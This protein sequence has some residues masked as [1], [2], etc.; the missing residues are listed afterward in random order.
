MAGARLGVIDSFVTAALSRPV[1]VPAAEAVPKCPF[2]AVEGTE[3]FAACDSMLTVPPVV[4]IDVCGLLSAVAWPPA[5]RDALLPRPTSLPWAASSDSRPLGAAIENGGVDCVVMLVEAGSTTQHD[6]IHGICPWHLA[7]SSE[8]CNVR[9]VQLLWDACGGVPD[10]T[11]CTIQCPGRLH[12]AAIVGDVPAMHAALDLADCAL[13]WQDGASALAV[14]IMHRRVDFVAGWLARRPDDVHPPCCGVEEAA[15]MTGL[16]APKHDPFLPPRPS[17]VQLTPLQLAVYCGQ[18]AMV[19]LLLDAGATYGDDVAAHVWAAL[20]DRERLFAALNGDGGDVWRR[21]LLPGCHVTV[22]MI[23]AVGGQTDIVRDIMRPASDALSR[24]ARPYVSAWE[25]ALPSAASSGDPA[26]MALLLPCVTSTDRD[27]LE[28]TM[29]QAAKRGDVPVADTVL[30]WCKFKTDTVRDRALR[31]ALTAALQAH[32][33]L[34]ALWAREAGAV[35]DAAVMERDGRLVHT[36]RRGDRTRLAAWATTSGAGEL[37]EVARALLVASEMGDVASVEV[38]LAALRDGA[39]TGTR[40]LVSEACGGA[41]CAAAARGHMSTLQALLSAGVP[42]D[43]AAASGRTA[44]MAAC[45]ALQLQAVTALLSAGASVDAVDAAG[46]TLLHHLASSRPGALPYSIAAAVARHLARLL[47]RHGAHVHA[48]TVHGQT[49]L[50]VAVSNQAWE[51][52]PLVD[53]LLE[54]GADPHCVDDEDC[55]A[56]TAAFLRGR[57]RTVRAI[58]HRSKVSLN[59]VLRNGELPLSQW[60]SHSRTARGYSLTTTPPMSHYD[61]L[62]LVAPRMH[63][64]AVN[65]RGETPLHWALA[66]L[67]WPAISILL[68]AGAPAARG[69][70]ASPSCFALAAALAARARTRPQWSAHA[71]FADAVTHRYTL[72]VWIRRRGAVVAAASIAAAG[73]GGEEEWF[74]M[75]PPLPPPLLTTGVG[76]T[77]PLDGAGGG[78]TGGV[79]SGV[80]GTGSGS[81]FDNDGDSDAD[82]YEYGGED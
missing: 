68:G 65:R 41:L 33:R 67:E 55:N 5:L 70:S 8:P 9:M 78:A 58:C 47:L 14:A 42:V 37:Q 25:A 1:V 26:L 50:A 21:P 64:C 81:A 15:A 39:T 19:R 44:L 4:G 57:A 66:Q 13:V 23:L 62:T 35:E 49:P 28:S 40:L 16:P 20:G 7:S 3:S 24:H 59:P 43:A 77:E 6:C 32:Q 56:L 69:T 63:L 51:T 18:S 29:A 52:A 82:G 11:T 61:I 48:C 12:L 75:L 53:T 76:P 79:S 34:F 46:C 54:A 2:E 17:T 74:R 80:G 60:S 10:F 36:V 72:H 71:T 38:L 31:S 30:D 27:L 73:R 22:A 45:R